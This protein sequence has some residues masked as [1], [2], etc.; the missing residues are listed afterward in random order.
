MPGYCHIYFSLTIVVGTLI[1][2]DVACCLCIFRA[3]GK[4]CLLIS[5]TKN[6]FPKDYVPT[7]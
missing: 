5:Y 1:M 2:W 4:T 6:E 3:V 7:V